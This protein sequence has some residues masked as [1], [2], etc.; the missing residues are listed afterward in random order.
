MTKNIIVY[1]LLF[2]FFT[3]QTGC[4]LTNTKTS[5]T[6]KTVLKTQPST[7]GQLLNDNHKSAVHTNGKYSTKN[8]PVLLTPKDTKACIKL[9][10]A[11]EI[12]TPGNDHQSDDKALILFKDLKR[13][14]ALSEQDYKFNNL[15]LKHVSQRQQLRQII[16]NQENYLKKIRVQNTVLHNQLSTLQSQLNQLKNIEVEIDKKERSVTS[17][18]GE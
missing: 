4:T 12:S 11:I 10:K 6:Q 7:C 15:L 2:C 16:S 3:M 14:K 9:H 18:I 13:S 5:N 8:S 17:P 1:G